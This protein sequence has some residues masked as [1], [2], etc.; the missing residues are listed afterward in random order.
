[1]Y[2]PKY[3]TIEISEALDFIRANGFAILISQTSGGPTATHLPLRVAKAG[4]RQILRGHVARANSQW[5]SWKDGDKVLAVFSGPHTYVSS[6]WYDHENVPT[7]NYQ[8]VHVHGTIRLTNP[9]ET[10]ESLRDLT[11]HYEQSSI[12]PV[13]VDGMSEDFLQREVRGLVGF[14]VRIEK[15]EGAFKLSQNRDAKNYREIIRRLEERGDPAS[16]YVARAMKN[17]DPVKA[18]LRPDGQSGSA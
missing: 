8:A 17:A 4:N 7:W 18:G 5:K 13:S 6:S 16:S 1:M 14:E 11:D 15:V 3:S 2:V 9:E 12:H 10:L